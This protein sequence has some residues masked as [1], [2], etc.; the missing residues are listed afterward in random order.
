MVVLSYLPL[1]Y[2]QILI[3]FKDGSLQLQ[4]YFVTAVDFK[5]ISENCAW[6]NYWLYQII[7]YFRFRRKH[8]TD[9]RLSC[10]NDRIL[11]DFDNGLLTG[12][13]LMY[14]QKTLDITGHKKLLEKLKAID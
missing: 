8:S 1:S 2:P 14:I 6:P 7:D 12:M 11:K 9:L 10:W 3:R 13:I 5:D 4:T